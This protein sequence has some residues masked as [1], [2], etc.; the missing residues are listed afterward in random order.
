MPGDLRIG[1]GGWTFAPWRGVLY[2]CGLPQAGELA[3]AT[4]AFSTLEIN[5][6]FYSTFGKATWS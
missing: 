3:F 1:I 4:R 6:T 5:G 2:P